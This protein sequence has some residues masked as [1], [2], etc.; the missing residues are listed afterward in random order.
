M[1]IKRISLTDASLKASADTYSFSGYAATFGDVDSYGDTVAPGAF[2]ATLRGRARPIRMRF[3]HFGPVIGLWKVI[4]E[5]A[6]GLYVEGELTRGHT[7]AENVYA[8]LK[9]GAIDGLSIGFFAK[10]SR[11]NGHGGRLLEEI[12][13]VE[14]SV[15]E[16]PAN[17]GASVEA[18]KLADVADG[19]TTWK[20]L[21]RY[22]KSGRGF[23][24][25]DCESLVH[26]VKRIS[27]ESR[28]QSVMERI[29]SR[30]HG[31]ASVERLLGR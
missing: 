24:N 18:V 1:E 25:A 5:D 17:M 13:L 22:L 3:N 16:E 30:L 11:A 8:S 26:T 27:R 9:H 12:D 2:R 28:H 31:A 23:S 19:L 10:R 6:N 7:V 21:E 29:A 14:I 15:V 4:R 20:D